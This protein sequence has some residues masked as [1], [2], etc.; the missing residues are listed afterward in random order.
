M[1]GCGQW[2]LIRTMKTLVITPRSDFRIHSLLAPL[3][4]IMEVGLIQKYDQAS[5]A[6]FCPDIIFSDEMQYTPDAYDLAK[7]S[8]LR[9]FINLVSF[10]E[11]VF[12][13]KYQS[14]IS[15][16]GPISDME[17]VLLD[18]YKMGYNVKNFF[19]SPSLLPCY[20]GSVGPNECWAIYKSATVSPIPKSD[21]GYRELD[22]IAAGGNPLKYT[23][24]EEFISEAIK[25]IKGKKFK[26]STSVSSI[27]GSNTNFDRIAQI[28]TEI[29]FSAIAKKVLQEKKCLV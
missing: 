9:P 7:V 15:Y 3:R 20:S 16:I 26:A 5:V 14:D 25:G 13:P 2:R 10:R 29:G 24:K 23:T 4:S 6:E 27:F 1:M 21:I 17:S 18:I 19:S 8:N 22:I 28:L 12:A 11:P